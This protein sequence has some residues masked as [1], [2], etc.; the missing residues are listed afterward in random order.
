VQGGNSSL[1]SFVINAGRQVLLLPRTQKSDKMLGN[2]EG[3]GG[4]GGMFGNADMV[5]Y[6]LDLS[7]PC[8]LVSNG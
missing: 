4:M 1:T 8:L 3:A 5:S 2:S 6:A 7:K